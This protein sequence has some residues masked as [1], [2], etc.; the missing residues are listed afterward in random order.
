MTMFAYDYPLLGFFWTV[1]MV[2]LWV[3]WII[4]LIRIFGDIFRNRDM[5]GGAKAFWSI[6]V[7]IFPLLGTLIYLI[8]HG[9]GMARRD[10][11]QAQQAQEAFDQYV[12]QAAGTSASSADELTKL[13]SL[14]D[15]GVIS[16][17]EFAAQKAK[18]L[19]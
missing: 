9:S 2:F 10:Q 1:L 14:R 7:I 19:A 4:L 11:Q 5:G 17:A 3:A 15:Q 18:L 8:A 12:R 6:F 16:D 13:A